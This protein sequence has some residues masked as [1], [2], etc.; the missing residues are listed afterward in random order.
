MSSKQRKLDVSSATGPDLIPTRMLRALY[1]EL[2]EP[3]HILCD[4]ILNSGR[5]PKSWRVHW[6]APIYKKGPQTVPKNYRGVHLTSQLSKVVERILKKL[7]LPYFTADSFTGAHQY[8]YLPEKG[9]RDVL[10]VLMCEWISALGLYRKIG[11]YCTDVSGAFDKVLSSRLVEKLRA[12]RLPESLTRLIMSWLEDRIAMVIVGGDH[13]M[14]S[15]LRNMVYQGTVLG[16]LLWAVFVA[17]ISRASSGLGFTERTYADDLT[18]CKTFPQATP[19]T[20]IMVEM[21]SCKAAVTKWGEANSVRFDEDKESMNVVSLQTPSGREFRILGVTID[22]R[23]TMETAVSEVVGACGWKVRSILQMK[24]YFPMGS[25]IAHFKAQIVSYIEYRTVALLHV[26]SEL[27]KRIDD[28][29]RNFLNDLGLTS[30]TA[31]LE[32]NLAPLNTRRDIAALGILHRAR[33]G[34]GPRRLREIFRTTGDG[35]EI[36]DDLAAG[37]YAHGPWNRTIP[38][39]R[40]SLFGRVALYNELPTAVRELSS[41]KAFQKTL[42]D[43]AKSACKEGA[44]GWAA[45]YSPNV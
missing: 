19:N 13:S 15:I 8:A 35:P 1:A 10:A 20:D 32:H 37:R 3:I 4:M 17:D 5:W 7:V 26:H 18:C 2:C 31:C 29:Q 27:T 30:V 25:R 42:Q 38:F 34:L 43:K 39:M 14:E 22:S 11:V 45:M 33:L 41:V 9:A 24:S 16:P 44:P 12:A 6:I 23:L 28:I 36:V 40:S 21:Q